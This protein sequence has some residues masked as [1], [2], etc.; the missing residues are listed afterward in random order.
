MEIKTRSRIVILS[1]ILYLLAGCFLITTAGLFT[2]VIMHQYAYDGKYGPRNGHAISKSNFD[3][4]LWLF[5]WFSAKKIEENGVRY[6]FGACLYIA[7]VFG[8]IEIVLGIVH[9]VVNPFKTKTNLSDSQSERL[10]ALGQNQY[11]QQ[12]NQQYNQQYHPV[13]NPYQHDAN[14]TQKRMP[15]YY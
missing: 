10:D 2:G 15:E 11:I 5:N 8:F 7:Y 14:M 13:M 12:Y 4:D 9:F 3:C 1:G 6:E